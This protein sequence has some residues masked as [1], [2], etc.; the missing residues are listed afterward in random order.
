LRLLSYALIDQ[1]KS[2]AAV[3]S[4]VQYRY[5]TVVSINSKING[6][7]W[8]TT[9]ELCDNAR[10]RNCNEART[11]LYRKRGIVETSK[12]YTNETIWRINEEALKKIDPRTHLRLL[13]LHYNMCTEYYKTS[14]LKNL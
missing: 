10:F 14:N 3:H 5:T 11:Y 4:T 8:M 1:H 7:K 2:V 13:T 12:I 9:R 6:I